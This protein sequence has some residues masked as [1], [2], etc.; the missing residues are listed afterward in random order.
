MKP[1]FDE[2]RGDG[3]PRAALFLGVFCVSLAVLLLQ[4][5]LT[6]IFSFTLW[7]HYAYVT[8]SVAL[9]GYGASGSFLAV[10]P[11]L[12]GR[13][14]A[15]RLTWL[16][17]GC[18]AAIVLGLVVFA[19]MPFHPF[20]LVTTIVSGKPGELDWM[21][22]VYLPLF[23]L[24]VITPF[25]L[26]GLC[27]STALRTCSA[28]VSRLYFFDLVGAAVGCLLVVFVI[29]AVG[30]PV[31]VVVAA[32]AATLAAVA[33]AVAAG[34]RQVGAALLGVVGVVAL[35][36]ATV[37]TVEFQ[38]SPEKFI[39]PYLKDPTT[40]IFS[41]AWTAIFRTDSY[42]L[43]DEELSRRG[44][45]AGWGVSP[46]WKDAA[47]T[48]APKIR[49]L[50]H[51]GDAGAV[52]Y[53]FD[54]DLA[55]LELFD[56]LILKTPYLVVDRPNVLVIGVGGGTDIVNAVKN[57]ARHVTGIELDPV[58]IDV[59]RNEQAEFAGHLYERPD[60][61]I[62][63]GEGR[64]TLRHSDERYDLIQLTG[65]DT[66][67][68]LSTGAYVL[69]ENYLYTTD[70]IHEFL[71][72]LTPNGVLS[73]IVADY[74][75]KSGYPRHT[76]RLLSLFL[77]ALE[78]D[79]VTD[80]ASRI[81]V[82]ASTEPVPQVNLLLKN[83]PFTPAELE[84]VDGFVKDKG[85]HVWAMPGRAEDT[86]HSRYLALPVA[87]RNAFRKAQ[88]LVITPTNDD[89]PFY[90]NFYTWTS[91]PSHLSEIDVGHTLATGQ[92]ILASMLVIATILSVALILGPL[93][94]FQ[95]QGLATEGR[96]GFIL[97]FSAIGLGFIFIE[98]SFVQKFV[99]FLGYPTYS[100]TV[101][102]CALL[103]SSG[104]GSFLTGRMQTPPEGRL[105]PLLGALT[106]MSLAY[107]FL[108][109]PLFETFLG[110]TFPMRVAIASVTL[111]PLGLVMGMFFPSGI[112]LV[113]RANPLFVPWA[114]AINGCASVVGT[115]LAVVLAMSW[116]FR[117]VT[118]MAIAIYGVGVL[119]LRARSEPARA[120]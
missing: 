118:I 99:L 84:R 82:V 71:D 67:A 116:G 23:Y 64:S 48:R 58:T 14:P 35:G 79:G 46:H 89:N 42:G 25:F 27:I 6:R 3:A 50:T 5:A 60:V 63:A 38:P 15:A 28:D 22:F 105:L 34:G 102:L 36:L 92:L 81:V 69:S 31:A 44:S 74:D 109:T 75:G 1:V 112:Q 9:L 62:V 68:A 19:E 41:H 76:M 66:L 72:H 91:L 17:L 55:K 47:M 54:G 83:S 117:A 93:V 12:P 77:Q 10:A 37:R 56:H 94:V 59:V 90:F 8:I 110:S 43:A 16:A 53:N 30:T 115:I 98:I 18:G 120:A 70:A 45:Y 21:Q 52:I 73:Y 114:W 111:V 13:V 95:R 113:R 103:L 100:L 107:L 86:G 106:L 61:T 26:A 65:V 87:E 32:G 4:I 24:A 11:E 78:E 2:S 29:N 85:F 80:A 39:A 57:H 96:W 119:A 49:L 20:R 97:F 88:P 33:F 101:V 51:D 7:Y 104:I 108:L 40:R